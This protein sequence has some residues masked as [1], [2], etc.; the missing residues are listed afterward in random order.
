[1]HTTYE[2]R[3]VACRQPRLKQEMVRISKTKN[4]LSLDETQKSGGR[5][6]YVCKNSA[7]ISK[8][9]DK[10]LLNKVFKTAIEEEIYSKLRGYIE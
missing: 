10:K 5:G 9:I 2:R 4:G 7:C 3:C 6:A 8:V 1:M